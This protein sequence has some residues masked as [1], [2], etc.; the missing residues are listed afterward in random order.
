MHLRQITNLLKTWQPVDYDYLLPGWKHYFVDD[1][2][3]DIAKSARFRKK[4][5]FVAAD[6]ALSN[7]CW[8]K[9]KASSVAIVNSRAI[10]TIT[11][12]MD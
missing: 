1:L 11:A 5:V 6:G 7:Y 4:Q 9:S 3:V 10:I 2:V 8:S 12:R